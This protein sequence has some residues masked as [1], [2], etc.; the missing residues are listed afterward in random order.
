[1][2][3][4][5]FVEYG[6]SVGQVEKCA[7]SRG[8]AGEH[9]EEKRKLNSKTKQASLPL[10]PGQRCWRALEI[11]GKEGVRPQED[12]G[13]KKKAMANHGYTICVIPR[14]DH[15]R[16]RFGYGSKAFGNTSAD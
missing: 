14:R 7:V 11:T 1:M 5:L 6:S 16:R 4:G 12:A 15:T 3:A 9:S 2:A 10:R 13:R 8:G